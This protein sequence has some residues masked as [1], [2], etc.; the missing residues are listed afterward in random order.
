MVVHNIARQHKYIAHQA[1]V[2]SIGHEILPFYFIVLQR[3]F[4]AQGKRAFPHFLLYTM[5]GY[6]GKQNIYAAFSPAAIKI[7][8]GGV[9]H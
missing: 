3:Y 8:G 5:N 9:A 1:H 2:P 4:F 6:T 7:K